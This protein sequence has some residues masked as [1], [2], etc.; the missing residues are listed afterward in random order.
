M[1][2]DFRV[3][4]FDYRNAR[5][6]GGLQ[7]NQ[8]AGFGIMLNDDGSVLFGKASVIQPIGS[9]IKLKG[10]IFTFPKT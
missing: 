5:Y 3:V 7:Q 2:S 6:Q 9:K 8:R 10:L 4:K 1:S